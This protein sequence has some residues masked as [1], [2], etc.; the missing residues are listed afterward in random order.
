MQW[1]HL[2]RLDLNLLV[3]LHALLE[4][5]SVTRA[6]QRVALS[7]SAMSRVFAR[8]RADFDDELL[9]RRGRAYERTG[10]GERLLFELRGLLPRIDRFVRG[11]P[12]DAATANHVFRVTGTDY[13]AAVI[14]AEL[15][16]RCRRPAPGIQV[17]VIGWSPE[18]YRLVEA[19]NCDLALGV[20][21][22]PAP[23]GSLK[24]EVL[25]EEEFVCLLDAGH[26]RPERKFTLDEYLARTHVC[27][28]LLDG[29]QAL[30]DRPLAEHGKTRTVVLRSPYLVAA[31]FSVAGTN[32]GLTTARRLAAR[33]AVGGQLRQV[34]PPDEIGR[35]PYVMVWHPRHNADPAHRWLRQQVR[36]ATRDGEGPAHASG[37]VG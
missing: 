7:Q 1:T 14:V 12:F 6:A 15:V 32:L 23:S 8:L 34:A 27:F 35:F 24:I 17:E 5:R 33:L 31:A 19:G 3:A 4:E 18:S 21:S 2:S 28:T 22:V 36:L 13:A 25:Y 16:R 29:Q 37:S 11:D 26:P 30:V 20:G 9:A 10:R